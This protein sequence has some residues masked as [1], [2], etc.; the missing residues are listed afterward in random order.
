MSTICTDGTDGRKAL[1]AAV[2][3]LFAGPHDKDVENIEADS[4]SGL[5]DKPK[6]LWS[7]YYIQALQTNLKD[8]VRLDVSKI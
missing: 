2:Q 7:V 4:V 5:T 3:A 1:E 6:L 8:L